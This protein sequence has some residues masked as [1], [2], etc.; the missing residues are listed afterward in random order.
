MDNTDTNVSVPVKSFFEEF[1]CPI[2]YVIIKDCTMTPC[3]HN[4]C[5]NCISESINR[6][7][8]CPICNSNLTSTQLVTNK[9]YDRLIGIIQIEKEK[10][11]KLY[12][13]K[14]IADS[15]HSNDQTNHLLPQLANQFSPIEQI[16]QTHMKRS[17]NSFETY[18]QSLKAKYDL[19]TNQIC[20]DFTAKMISRQMNSKLPEISTD[21]QILNW[22]NECDEKVR[23]VEEAFKE[24]TSLLLQAYDDYMKNFA[25]A[26][27]YLPITVTVQVPS[28]NIQFPNMVIS[29]TDTVVQVRE[30]IIQK[31]AKKGDP[32]VT[33]EGGN[34]MVLVNNS[35]GKE[36]VIE[37]ENVPIVQYRPDPGSILIFKGNLICKSDTPKECFKNI[38]VKDNQMKMDYYTCKQCKLRRLCKSCAETCHKDHGITEYILNHT[39]TW[40]CCYCGKSGFCC[41]SKKE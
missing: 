18:Y 15:L 4:F 32:V 27:E 16:F 7:K 22:K 31:M 37:K 25:P 2:C 24:S 39:P 36:I 30:Q 20:A 13:E 1:L 3:S 11:S 41:L 26:P 29:P 21:Q 34:V 12:F 6:K 33:C 8:K 19:Q 40:G 28:K 23:G 38:F 14:L 9:S 35:T 5:H 10:A 17:L